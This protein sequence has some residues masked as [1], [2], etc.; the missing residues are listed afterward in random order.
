MTGV[1]CEVLLSHFK[2]SYLRILLRNLWH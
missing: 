1:A 2:H